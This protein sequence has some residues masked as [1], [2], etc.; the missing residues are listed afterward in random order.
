MN[1]AH[2]NPKKLIADKPQNLFLGFEL[3]FIKGLKKLKLA[4]F[5]SSPVFLDWWLRRNGVLSKKKPA[6]SFWRQL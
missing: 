6:S 4:F 1:L 3:L 5:R 2:Q